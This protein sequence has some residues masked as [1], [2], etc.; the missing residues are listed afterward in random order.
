MLCTVIE[1]VLHHDVIENSV[2][3]LLW[4]TS[5]GR[6]PGIHLNKQTEQTCEV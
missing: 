1:V 5:Q 6:D 2:S 4:I 3:H